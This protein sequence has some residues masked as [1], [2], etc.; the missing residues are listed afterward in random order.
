MKAA[1]EALALKFDQWRA[2][3]ISSTDL[4][5]AI[6]EY[7]HGIGREI[8]KRYATNDPE[9]SLAYAVAVGF[10]SRESLPQEVAEHI[11][12]SVDFFEQQMREE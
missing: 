12:S 9:T 4:H 11:A 1:L 5:D 3:A 6:H 2:E 10:L 8:W 7:H